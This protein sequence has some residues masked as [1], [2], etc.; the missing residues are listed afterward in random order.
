[1]FIV[2]EY[3]ALTRVKN[4]EQTMAAPWLT[5]SKKFKRVHSA[6]KVMASIVWDS[7]CVIMI[8]YLEQGRSI[9]RRIEAVMPRS[10]IHGLD[11]VLATITIRHRSWQSVLVRRFPCCIHI[12]T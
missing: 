2:T 6:E 11:A 5:P 8:D 3:A 10:H 9:N 1:M 12:H 4:A 7:Q